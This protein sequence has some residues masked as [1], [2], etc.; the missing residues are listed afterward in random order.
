MDKNSP[1]I[2]VGAA[3]QHLVSKDVHMRCMFTPG[4]FQ[5]VLAPARNKKY[6]L[7]PVIFKFVLQKGKIHEKQFLNEITF[8]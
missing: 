6:I 5:F 4:I 3:T 1:K 7:K 2:A 8:C